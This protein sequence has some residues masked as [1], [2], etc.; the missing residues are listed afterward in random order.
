MRDFA[1]FEARHDGAERV[2]CLPADRQAGVRF[3]AAFLAPC[4]VT[5][6]AKRC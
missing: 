5:S 3:T 4:W 6:P 2:E 1:M